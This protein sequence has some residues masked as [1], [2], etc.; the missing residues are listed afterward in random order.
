MTQYPNY[1]LLSGRAESTTQF[2]VTYFCLPRYYQSPLTGHHIKST[3]RYK[4]QSHLMRPLSSANFE[5]SIELSPI[6]SSDE[7]HQIM[8]PLQ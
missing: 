2:W 3:C 6:S 5:V 4:L 8:L 1:P 7:Q